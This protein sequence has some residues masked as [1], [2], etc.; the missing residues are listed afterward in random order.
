MHVM[1]SLIGRYVLAPLAITTLMACSDSEETP[2]GGPSGAGG[3]GRG[4]ASGM[5]GGPGGS[6]PGGSNG[7]GGSGNT[8]NAGGAGGV[9]GS[10]VACA[11][12][13]T[14]ALPALPSLG[15]LTARVFGNRARIKI[16][17]FS[18][19][20]DYRAYTLPADA[21]V[22]SSASGLVVKD[23]VYRCAGKT[24]SRQGQPVLEIE[25]PLVEAGKVVVVE[26]LDAGCPYTGHLAFKAAPKGTFSQ[27]FVTPDQA[28]NA[29]TGELYIN[30]HFPPTSAP[31]P[32]ARSFACPEP[33]AAPTM[34]FFQDFTSYNEALT[35][36]STE[37]HGYQDV[38]LR[39]NSFDISFQQIEEN[40]WS[41]GAVDRQLWVAYADWGA[42]VGAKFRATL[43]HT[44][45]MSDTT[46]IHATMAVDAISTHRRYP[47]IWI[48]S[49]AV[50]VQNNLEQGVTLNLETFGGA[51]NEY[52]P[53]QICD[54]RHWDVNEQCPMFLN[55]AT[56]NDPQP[57]EYEE[58][59]AVTLPVQFDLYASTKRAYVFYDGI[60]IQCANLPAGAFTAGQTVS[61]TIGDVLYHS[62]ADEAIWDA[63]GPS[64][65]QFHSEYQPTET[66]RVFEDVG[67]SEGVPEPQWPSS[68]RCF[69]RAYDR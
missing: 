57:V 40:A 55:P 35:T 68:I 39:N 17:A 63:P 51:G 43:R 37:D 5:G 21:N 61:M 64:V 4:G 12:G 2:S 28:K 69:D 48:S 46:F 24:V 27:P 22:M 41:F 66:R 58:H 18:G 1:N 25:W 30:G 29:Q 8:G 49:A 16:P 45:K 53:F 36:T 34:D 54:H 19:A 67:L 9:G 47:Q 56:E 3:G 26:A 31:K 23:A 6:G 13:V 44:V 33:T 42:D 59:T 50:P 11:S 65:Y 20:R 62:G 10:P 38:Y 52:L 15:N 32:I 14:S 60:P 7:A